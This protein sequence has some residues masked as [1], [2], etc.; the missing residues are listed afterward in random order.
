MT[1]SNSSSSNPKSTELSREI[2]AKVNAHADRSVDRLF[3]D[4]DELLKNDTTPDTPSS[5]R[6]YEN[7]PYSTP[8]TPPKSPNSET[9]F[10]PP[11]HP[12]SFAPSPSEAPFTP[13][14]PTPFTPPTETP[15]TPPNPQIQ[16]LNTDIPFTPPNYFQTPEPQ[17]QPQLSFQ[18][19]PAPMQAPEIEELATTPKKSEVPLWVKVFLSIGFI[20]IASSSVL[21]W[22]IKE[23]KITLPTNLNTSWIPGET[24]SQISP[25]DAK[26]A[27]YMRKSISK[28]ES[29]NT[30]TTSKLPNPSGN[31]ANVVTPDP[32]NP[33]PPTNSPGIAAAP[34]DKPITPLKTTASLTKTMQ[35]GDRIGAT[36]QIGN[37]AQTV[38]V[39]DKIGNTG[40]SLLT[41]AENSIVV[42]KAGRENKSIAIGQKF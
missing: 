30:T 42:V 38:N 23:G 10:T 41:V 29:A 35:T 36:F 13:P 40:W 26:F 4:I 32:Y 31:P 28:I 1:N 7:A 27:D 9:P 17:T 18:T 21:L 16:T 15:F 2:L 11:N 12:T 3:A 25:D 8:F 20:S 37:R 5:D 22:L 19:Q 6:L 14:T 39:G 33:A 24:Q 34:T